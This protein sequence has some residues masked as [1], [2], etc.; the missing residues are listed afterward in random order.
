MQKV[1]HETC[2]QYFQRRLSEGWKC[3]SLVGYDAVLQSPCG[4]TLRHIDLRNDIETL[5]PNAAGDEENISYATSGAGH[6]YEDV[7][8]AV[9]DD[10][11]TR[12]SND[13]DSYQRDL[14]NLPASSGSGTIN[15]ITI[16]FR[17]LC[18]MIA[19]GSAKASIKSDSTVTDGIGKMLT[20]DGIWETLSQ[21]WATNPADEP[22]AWTWNDIDALQIGVSIHGEGGEGIPMKITQVYVEV[23]Y[24]AA[25]WANIGKVNGVT[26][27]DLAKV[28]GVAVADVAKMSGVAV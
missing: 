20:K 5:R 8:E 21:E 12:I 7:D 3:I 4:G 27:T 18:E 10:D 22:S 1:L 9:A 13:T 14:Y 23:D 19:A 6:H 11:T 17:G 28:N 16:F 2:Q 24:S 15:K 26:A 25:G